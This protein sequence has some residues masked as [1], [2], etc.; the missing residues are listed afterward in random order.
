[1]VHITTKKDIKIRPIAMLYVCGQKYAKV[2]DRRLI[3]LSALPQIDAATPVC[4]NTDAQSLPNM[5][6][7]SSNNL[8]SND[9]SQNNN[10]PSNGASQTN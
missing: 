6:T 10:L 9:A 1:M 4:N 8:P 2:V 3:K 7:S 5:D